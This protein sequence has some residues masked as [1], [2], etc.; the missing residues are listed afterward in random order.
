MERLSRSKKIYQIISDST[1]HFN[2]KHPYDNIESLQIKFI[3]QIT[4]IS[5]NNISMELNR[6]FT[7][8]LVMR[9]RGRPVT[10]FSIS[11]LEELLER[12]LPT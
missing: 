11:V 5:S 6:M 1:A 12:H 7:D 9:V 4:G 10:Y 8:G 2:P 3:S